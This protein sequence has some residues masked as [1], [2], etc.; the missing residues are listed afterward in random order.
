MK[1]STK[2]QHGPFYVL[3]LLIAVCLG[4]C[5]YLDVSDD[6]SASDSKGFI[7]QN[8]G[9]SI[10]FQRYIYKA[11][12]N[13][14]DYAGATS[15]ADGLGNPWTSMSD[16]VK[17]NANGYLRDVVLQGYNSTASSFHRWTA[18]YRVIRQA[19]IYI[20]SARIIGVN[21]DPDFIDET[22]L[23]QLK[24]EAYFF[25]AYSHYL[26]FEQY[27]PIPV[28][29]TQAD[30]SDPD[31]D[32]ARSPVDE[33]VKAIDDDLLT[34]IE[35]LDENR[36]SS[37]YASGFEEN[38]LAIPTKGV[39]MA[40][41][42]KL[43]MLAAS[44]LMNGGYAE[45]LVLKNP[46]GT[47]LF[48]AF[49]PAKW[50]KAKE[51]LKA[52]IDFANAGNY[53][54]YYSATPNNP[55]LNVYELFQRY[56]KEIIWANAAN[57]WGAVQTAQTPRDI[58]SNSGGSTGGYMGVTQEAVD[59]FFMANGLKIDDPNA[60]YTEVGFSDV[61]NPATQYV[62]NGNTI[63]LTDPN[64][65]NMYAN[66]EP[67]FYASV[68]YQGKSWHD[69]VS[70][71]VL[72]AN[73]AAA[74]LATRVFFSRDISSSDNF[75]FP[76][77]RGIVHSGNAT[78]G[79]HPKTGYLL[80]KFANRT[81][82]PT[83]PGAVRSVFRP[84]IIFRLADFYL[85]YAE[86]CNEVD[87]ADPDIVQYIDMVRARAG[88]PGYADMQ[89]NGIKTGIIGSQAAQREAIQRERR[90]ELFAEGQRYFDVRRWMIAEQPEGRQGGT[91]HGMN[92][93]GRQDDLTYFART[94]YDRA[95]RIF[96][97]AM[98]LYPIPYSE[99]SRSRLLVQ[100]PG[101]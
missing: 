67:R 15:G 29:K 65:S 26:L 16:E 87:P 40:V 59:A 90:I 3:S 93:D 36:F 37:S 9:Q 61:L 46:D 43:W 64:V 84:A 75:P 68:T 18:L 50:A 83:A 24:A 45:A 98:Y 80:Y 79:G 7:F 13:Y 55:Y 57:S 88:I 39:A 6:F 91:F 58:Q 76:G 8:P 54:L 23:K 53:E 30:P 82:H 28:M 33:V 12:P 51:V 85:L 47:N 48:P 100:N 62:R 21:G 17:N 27:G 99:L 56:N 20:D 73:T 4:G 2:T 77:Y 31:S 38:K 78:A 71:R 11:M 74:A 10:R 94:D 66:R 25:R 22:Q 44:P 89:Q 52:F 49:D 96:Q 101:Y 97:K 35:G 95:P 92:L 63:T 5:D 60:G 41:R 32:F 19:T 70:N 69:V 86:A 14:S 34:A 1:N 72:Q 42:A 81:I